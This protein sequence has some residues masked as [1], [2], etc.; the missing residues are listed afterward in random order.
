MKIRKV[1]SLS[2]VVVLL[3]QLTV[4]AQWSQEI[5]LNSGINEG[6]IWPRIQS[7]NDGAIV[8]W[9]NGATKDIY[10][11]VVI[12]D[13][14]IGPAFTL[15]ENSEDA[16]I[17]GWASTELSADGDVVVVVYKGNDAQTGSSNIIVSLDGGMNFSDPVQIINGDSVLHR[18]PAIKVLGRD[19]YVSY[20]AFEEGFHD[21]QWEIL[22]LSELGNGDLQWS[23]VTAGFGGEACDCCVSNVLATDNEVV[24]LF[25]NNDMNFRDI[26]SARSNSDSLQFDQF[27]DLNVPTW[28]LQSCPSTGADGHISGDKLYSTFMSGHT[29]RNLIYLS[30]A[31][32]SGGSLIQDRPLLDSIGD[33]SSYNYPRMAGNGDTIGVV[34]QEATV[35]DFNVF[36]SYSTEG[37]QGLGK[38]AMLVS[39]SV[40]GRQLNPDIAFRNGTFY[41]TWQDNSKS[42]VKYRSYQVEK[43]SN[44]EDIVDTDKFF[45]NPVENLLYINDLGGPYDH[46]IIFDINGNEI[47]KRNYNDEIDVSHLSSGVYLVSLNSKSTESRNYRIIKR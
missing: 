26:Y 1:S 47:M 22:R 12:D 4:A 17:T 16:F 13:S 42:L 36:F 29:G 9:G 28:E 34:W 24:V 27:I 19:L 30:E 11:N 46:I 6:F 45:P 43:T 15:N 31:D 8:I 39:E 40:D 5:S 20:M 7:T 3:M 14:K 41:F 25:R 33:R 18:F 23:N 21:P 32:L 10:A 44:V 2:I 38:Q 35:R 37:L